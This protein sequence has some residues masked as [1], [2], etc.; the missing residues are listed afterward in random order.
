MSYYGNG[1]NYYNPSIPHSNTGTNYQQHPTSN[2]PAD[3][4]TNGGAYGYPGVNTAVR[5]NS[6]ARQNDELF[7]G[8]P[9]ASISSPTVA[10]PGLGGYGSQQYSQAP[11]QYNPQ[12][13]A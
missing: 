4:N 1:Q 2:D 5:R 3:N 9:N 12:H 6:V 8:D 11:Q 13:Y 10:S 7:I